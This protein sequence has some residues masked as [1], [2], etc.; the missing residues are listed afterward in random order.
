MKKV[1]F[2]KRFSAIILVG[3]LI[4]TI[5]GFIPSSKQIVW[6]TQTPQSGSSATGEVIKMRNPVI[7]SGAV[8]I[9]K[10]PVGTVVPTSVQKS[11]PSI[12]LLQ[13]STP[14]PVIPPVIWQVT[15]TLGRA[16]E[17]IPT[18]VNVPK[19]AYDCN[20]QVNSPYWYQQFAPGEDFD[21]DVTITNTGTEAWNTDIDVMQYTGWRMEIEGKYLY[22]LDKDYDSA[23]IVLPGQSIRWKIRME[24]PKEKTT[25]DDKYYTTY[26]LVKGTDYDNS[27]FCPF[28]LYIYVPHK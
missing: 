3:F 2:K 17:V 16:V 11:N 28:S 6:S 20:V 8:I 15:P 26:S 21:F 22:D 5:L 14:M 9:L 13:T 19:P 10:N 18:G 7:R 4:V 23:Q 27:R 12:Q 1:L 24:A 25:E